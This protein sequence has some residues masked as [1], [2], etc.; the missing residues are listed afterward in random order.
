MLLLIYLTY[1]AAVFY[2]LM[3]KVKVG[4]CTKRKAI[5]LHSAHTI[6][7]VVLYGAV[8]MLLIG[9]EEYTDMAIIGEGYARILP[10]VVLGGVAVVALTT[11]IFSLVV[12]A[13]K[14]GNTN[15]T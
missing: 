3:N 1:V 10:F 4:K 14:R 15:A 11:L 13:M 8:F 2:W 9:V 7:P 6:F 5:V 12:L